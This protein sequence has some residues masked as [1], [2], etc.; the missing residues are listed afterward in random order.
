MQKAQHTDCCPRQNER[1]PEMVGH[2]AAG[3]SIFGRSGQYWNSHDSRQSSAVCGV[4]S[5]IVVRCPRPVGERGKGIVDDEARFQLNGGHSGLQHVQPGQDCRK[6]TLTMEMSAEGGRD[7]AQTGE[8][9]TATNA[10]DTLAEASSKKQRTINANA[11]ETEASTSR[12]ADRDDVDE[13]TSPSVSV[14]QRKEGR[15]GDRNG[16]QNGQSSGHDRNKQQQGNRR[17]WNR[18]GKGGKDKVDSR[19]QGK[20]PQGKQ[21]ERANSADA[22]DNGN[23]EGRLPK[24]KVA[25]LIGY[26]GLGYSGSQMCGTRLPDYGRSI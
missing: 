14:R 5:T 24:R 2:G 3:R 11:A 12:P 16:K 26:S 7:G 20:R 19:R 1:A 17:E 22:N 15:K 25:M 23:A 18:D 4:Q 8:K 6:G 10:G 13:Q 21:R 9:R